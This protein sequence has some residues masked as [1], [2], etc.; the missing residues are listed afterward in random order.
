MSK[1]LQLSLLPELVRSP[2][3]RDVA[4]A[5][6]DAG[7]EGLPSARRRADEARY[8]EVTVRSA[9]AKTVGMPFK[10]ALNP[11]RGCTHACEY[12]YARKYQRHLELGTGDDFSSVILV[13]HN[14]A[15]VLRRELARPQWAREH[16]AVGTATD[17][18]QPIEGHYRLT[19]RCLE[20]LINSRTPFSVVTKGPMV[21]RD[22]DLLREATKGA[23]CEVYLSV[24]SVDEG[25]WARLEPGTASPRQRIRAVRQL[26]DAGIE[27]G[28]LMM[29]LVPGITTTRDSIE[30]TLRALADA[31]VR[32]VGANVAR[33]DPGVKEHFFAFLAREYPHLVEGYRR[34]YPRAYA[35]KE[36]AEEL[37]ATVADLRLSAFP[38]LRL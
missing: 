15:E 29:P 9:M 16:V 5:V 12:C 17:P 20:A 18:Y 24:P 13:K 1:A 32:Q 36:Y 21:V 25:A 10:W 7:I 19:R 23:G 38:P 3:L 35:S 11:Y 4:D 14:L 6:K 30:K 28:V 31:G 34:L 2:T 26:S 27:T 8:Q 33:L 22:L 37:R